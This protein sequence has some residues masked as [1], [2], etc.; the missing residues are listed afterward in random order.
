MEK[1]H[2][3]LPNNA[4][5]LEPKDKL[6]YLSIRRFMN[7]ETK[8]AFPSLQTISDVSGA[9]IPTIRKIISKLEELD[10]FEILKKGRGQQ[11]KFNELKSFE[12]FSYEFLDRTDLSFTSK[13]YLIASQEFMYK[14]LENFGKISYSDREMSEKI[15]MSHSTIS[16][17][18]KELEKLG[19]LS[20]VKNNTKEI[21]TDC[22]KNTKIYNLAKLGQE[23]IW[24]L[25]NHENRLNTHEDRI[26][27]LE[28]MIEKL[29][30]EN[31]KLKGYTQ[32]SEII[33][34]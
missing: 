4:S 26:Q 33:M 5:D 14:D 27:K 1:Q 8:I 29:S 31:I 20:I 12:P 28:K 32:T 15:N 18:N 3:Q 19:V 24:T 11:Y 25:Q 34:D 6:V 16:K 17:C 30:E 22:N 7:K 23:I 10:Y 13:S 9:S 2:V 21:D